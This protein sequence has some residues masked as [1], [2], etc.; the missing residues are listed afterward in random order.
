MAQTT[1]RSSLTINQLERLLEKR[2]SSLDALMRERS[3]LEK[4]LGT[5]DS[6]IRALSGGGASAAGSLGL[7]RGG[8]ARNPMSLVAAME[9]VLTKA[10]K[11]LNVGDI[12]DKVHV[13]GYHSNA[14]NFRALVNQTLIKQRKLFANAGRG[15]YEI[16]K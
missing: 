11:P 16:K 12:V 3:H 9:D 5:I 1:A 13:L 4:R 14:A 15:M 8:R 7:T 2:R 6:R 10:G